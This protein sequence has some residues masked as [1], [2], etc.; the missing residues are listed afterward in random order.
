[1]RYTTPPP[2]YRLPLACLRIQPS[3][4]ELG[5]AF[6]LLVSNTFKYRGRILVTGLS[7]SKIKRAT[8]R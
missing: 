7:I 3:V 6:R 4:N 1:M 2:Y 8:V 5:T